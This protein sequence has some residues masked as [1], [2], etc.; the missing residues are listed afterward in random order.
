MNPKGMI[1]TV[2]GSPEPIT[3]ALVEAIP[4]CVLFVV[5]EGSKSQVVGNIL[6]AL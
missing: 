5:S 3:T 4:D 1:L 2:G 6:P